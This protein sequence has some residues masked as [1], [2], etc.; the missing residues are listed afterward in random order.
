M[1]SYGERI[2]RERNTG[3]DDCSGLG[4]G[5]VRNI[6]FIQTTYIL[7]V[8]MDVN[9]NLHRDKIHGQRTSMQ[10]TSPREWTC[11]W[12]SFPL[13]QSGRSTEIVICQLKRKLDHHNSRMSGQH[14]QIHGLGGG[15]PEEVTCSVCLCYYLLSS[16]ELD[17][18]IA[19]GHT[20]RKF[21]TYHSSE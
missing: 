10:S 5:V 8:S 7:P 14:V 3:L 11:R 21:E 2:A 16:P 1:V 12:L 15:A 18:W 6:P 17:G 13:R 19:Q 9:A 20:C 4:G